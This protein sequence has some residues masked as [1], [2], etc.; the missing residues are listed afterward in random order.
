MKVLKSPAGKRLLGDRYE[1]GGMSSGLAT[2]LAAER[3][4]EE[5]L[6]IHELYARHFGELSFVLT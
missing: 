2:V 4:W 3:R 1:I 5:A 6:R